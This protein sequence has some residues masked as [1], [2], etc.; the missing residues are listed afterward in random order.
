MATRKQALSVV[1]EEDL[2]VVIRTLLKTVRERDSSRVVARVRAEC[3][4][5]GP[6]ALA[7]LVDVLADAFSFNEVLFE[8]CTY[9]TGSSGLFRYERTLPCGMYTVRAA[10][11]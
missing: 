9:D 8:V 4:G 1:G 6:T 11:P 10:I 7:V 5:L 2:P 3:A